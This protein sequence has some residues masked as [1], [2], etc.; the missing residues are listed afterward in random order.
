MLKRWLGDPAVQ[1]ALCVAVYFAVTW[2]MG[3][4]AMVIASPLLGA[5]IALPLINLASGVRHRVREATWL[6]KHGQHYVFRG[7]TLNVIEDD[8]Y[9]RWVRLADARKVFPIVATERVLAISYPGR[10]K[11]FGNARD[12]Y[13]RDD[14]LVEHLGKETD[15]VALRFRTWVDRTIF[16]PADK[17]RS[18]RGI[19]PQPPITS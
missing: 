17:V 7:V 19:R 15:G 10:V 6:P 11:A 14:A 8:D 12:A 3:A 1:I 2:H 16:F 5:A 13:M 4:T 18:E 9:C